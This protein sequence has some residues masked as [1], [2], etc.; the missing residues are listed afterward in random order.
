MWDTPTAPRGDP[1]ERHASKPRKEKNNIET[2]T[3]SN[4][5]KRIPA[6]LLWA[7]SLLLLLPAASCTD[8][9]GGDPDTDARAITF[10]PA[11]ETRA[12]V[13]DAD[14]MADGFKVW[15]WYGEST[16]NIDKNVFN[17]VIVT[18]GTDGWGYTGTQYWIPG[19]KY[20]FYGVYPVYPKTSSDN[21]TTATVDNKGKITVTNFDCSKTGEEA[22]DLM[23][24]MATGDGSDPKPVAM[25]FQHQLSK[26]NIVA[27]VEGGNCTVTSVTFSG[28]ATQGSYNSSDQNQW[29]TDT[30]TGSFTNEEQK[31]LNT[32]GVDLLGDLLLIPQTVT[33]QFKIKVKYNLDGGEEQTK[34]ITLPTSIGQ[35]EAGQSYKYTLT[36]K[37]NNIIF[38]VN[39][40][41]WGHSTG[42]IITVE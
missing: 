22:V 36:F 34:D 27:T 17:G 40:A 13:D 1:N 42:G 33:N 24:A 32:T 3:N 18:K 15:G 11:A 10:T 2:K 8:T 21:G 39:V 25:K 16:G 23:T 38:T 12:A 5:M 7:S 14:D 28:M 9:L 6:T 30:T 29:T 19:M 37:G 31:T 20:N 26:V 35:W 4:D 41:S